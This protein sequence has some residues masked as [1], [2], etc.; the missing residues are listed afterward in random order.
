MASMT[1]NVWILMKKKSMPSMALRRMENCK[2]L[3]KALIDQMRMT[4]TMIEIWRNLKWMRNRLN[5][6]TM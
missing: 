3:M 1:M 5:P 2:A 6:K 4:V